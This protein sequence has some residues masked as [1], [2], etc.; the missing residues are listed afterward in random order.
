MLTNLDFVWS[1]KHRLFLDI[2]I[3]PG[4]KGFFSKKEHPSD[5]MEGEIKEVSPEF[6]T[7]F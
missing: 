4:K 6:L 2:S 1:K 5:Y 7:Q 3:D